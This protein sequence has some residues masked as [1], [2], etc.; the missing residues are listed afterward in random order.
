M[1][2]SLGEREVVDALRASLKEEEAM[3]KWIDEHMDET[4]REFMQR[5]KSGAKAKR[6]AA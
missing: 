6:S 3:A 2:D 4:V 1:A 5:T